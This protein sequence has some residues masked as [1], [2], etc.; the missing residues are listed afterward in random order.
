[1]DH[2]HRWSTSEARIALLA[3]HDGRLDSYGVE[4]E[5]SNLAQTPTA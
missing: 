3:D 2:A 5:L 4:L 1:V